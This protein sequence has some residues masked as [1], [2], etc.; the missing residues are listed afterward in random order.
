[1]DLTVNLNKIIRSL[2]ED[3]KFE[4]SY[5]PDNKDYSPVGRRRNLK[6]KIKVH[7]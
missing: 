4:A 2:P 3:D 5:N 7:P 1:L 6:N